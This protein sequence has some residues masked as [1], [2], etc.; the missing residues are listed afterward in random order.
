MGFELL[1]E[2]P[3][4]EVARRAAERAVA[5]LAS[6][7]APAGQMPVVIASGNG[8]G[9]FHESSGHGMEADLIAKEASVYTGKQGER[10]GDERFNGVDDATVEGG[11]GAHVLHEEGTPAHRTPLVAAGVCSNYLTDLIRA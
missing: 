1:D 11:W 6:K 9:L 3:P 7:P 5:M 10:I 2:F 4:E 8:G